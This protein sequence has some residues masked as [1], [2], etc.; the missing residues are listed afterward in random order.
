MTYSAT[1]QR[2]Q[3]FVTLSAPGTSWATRSP[4]SRH[5]CPRRVLAKGKRG[6]S[7]T[8]AADVAAVH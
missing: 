1:S 4:F 2:V 5:G 8:R 7:T 6:A 3:I